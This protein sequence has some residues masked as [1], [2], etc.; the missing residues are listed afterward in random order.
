MEGE[1]AV[2]WMAVL[3][4]AVI[5]VYLMATGFNILNKGKPF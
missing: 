4:Y 3:Q 1:L 5:V 2:K